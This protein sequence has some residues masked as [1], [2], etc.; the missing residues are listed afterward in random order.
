[1]EAVYRYRSN[2]WGYIGKRVLLAIV[3]FFVISLMIFSIINLDLGGE[4]GHLPINPSP[5]MMEMMEQMGFYD[6]FITR[7]FKW[8]GSIFQGDFGESIMGESYY[9]K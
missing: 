5:D 7:Y 9:T 4:I 6:S 1:M 8:V 2:W 3:V